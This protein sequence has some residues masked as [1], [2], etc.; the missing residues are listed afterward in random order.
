M[1]LTLQLLTCIA[2]AS[3]A[4]IPGMVQTRSGVAL[5]PRAA[6]GPADPGVATQP[7]ASEHPDLAG[8]FAGRTCVSADTRVCPELSREGAA[9]LLTARALAFA[10]AFDELA[11]PKY[12]CGP[13]TLPGLFG[14]PYAFEVEQLT[15]R[16]LLRYE[17]DDVV[18]TIWLEGHG[19]P[20][21]AVGAF[22]THGYS[23]GRYEGDEL[24]VETT[25][26]TFDP[27][28]IA[29]D[30]ISAPSSTQKRLLERYSRDGDLLRMSLTVEDSIFLLGPIEFVMEW[31]PTD[32]ALSLPWN[33]DPEAA[34][35]NLRLVPTKYPQ[36]P[37]I[38][39]RD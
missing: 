25:R 28:G 20:T 4:V 12:D 18:R 6:S 5:S 27:T 17:K 11:A 24:V 29:G 39:R 37:A 16:V 33:C 19:H 38:D 7:S 21:P 13:A 23:T 26:F 34:Q 9:E 1:H 14:D 3:V 15:D 32:R 35:R 31:R 36:D 8:V 2:L 10:E 22:F 30:F